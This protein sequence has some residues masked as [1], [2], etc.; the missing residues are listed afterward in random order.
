[1][2]F[3]LWRG[4]LAVHE[5][6]PCREQSDRLW[7]DFEMGHC[8]LK[9][10]NLHQVASFKVTQHSGVQYTDSFGHFFFLISGSSGYNEKTRLLDFVFVEG[11]GPIA[12]KDA[13]IHIHIGFGYWNEM[14]RH[15][16]I[17]PHIQNCSMY[18]CIPCFSSIS[19]FLLSSNIRTYK[20]GCVSAL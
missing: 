9:K 8:S 11:N 2:L 12:A 1:M 7:E 18:S 3:Q 15:Q 5:S 4:T 13:L 17:I 6:G 19:D 14:E 20:A 16:H 10:K